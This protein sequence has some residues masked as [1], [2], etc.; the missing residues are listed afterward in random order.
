MSAPKEKNQPTFLLMGQ[1][2]IQSVY[3]MQ[4]PRWLFSDPRYNDLSLD[5]K[6]TYTFLLNRFQL[7]R[8]NKWVNDRGEVFVIFPRRALASELRICEKRVSS[9]F[10]ALSALNLIWEK[11][12]GRGAA[13]HIF[14]ARVQPIEDPNYTCAPFV[15]DTDDGSRTADM[16][17]LAE[18]GEDIAPEEPPNPPFQNSQ[19]GGFRTAQ[20]ATPEPPNPPP[21]YINSSHTD[22]SQKDSSQSVPPSPQQI[23]RQRDGQMDA[24][25]ERE[26]QEILGQCE[27]HQFYEGTADIFED[28]IERLFRSNGYR[29]GGIYFPQHR[30]RAKLHKLTP[31]V[32][33]EVERKL[34]E[35]T[36]DEITNPTSYIMAAIFNGITELES[37][38][39]LGQLSS[40][41]Y[42]G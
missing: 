2:D 1:G 42:M 17:T 39:L 11:R 30:V 14:L 23:G 28:A 27:L 8:R 21:S 36:G 10:A 32:L 6:M 18:D 31:D 15:E 12:L 24:V 33:C 4:M 9:A 26:L 13:N 34:E 5:A 41:H 25:A 35:R 3:H 38:L 37:S 22:F 16:E 20:K 19:N 7:S 29:V 40:G